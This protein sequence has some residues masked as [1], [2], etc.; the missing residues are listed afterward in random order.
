V[1]RF[2]DFTKPFEVHI[3]VSDF[4]ID[5]VFMQNGHLIAFESKKLCGA[6]LRWPTH[7]KELYVIVCC[8]KS[9]Q[10]YLGMHKI[11]VYMDKISL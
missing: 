2:L 3:D 11:K 7:E 6:R 4:A 5:G 10:Y 8:L 1:L 9:W